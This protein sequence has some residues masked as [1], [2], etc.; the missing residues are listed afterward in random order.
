MNRYKCIKIIEK[1]IKMII[2]FN[3]YYWEEKKKAKKKSNKKAINDE[4]KI[5]SSLSNALNAEINRR[6]NKQGSSILAADL[7]EEIERR[8]VRKSSIYYFAKKASF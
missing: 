1:E 8:R 6:K 4:M 5:I 3:Y 2:I 7:K